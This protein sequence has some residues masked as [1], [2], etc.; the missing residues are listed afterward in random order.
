MKVNQ[1]LGV[2]PLALYVLAE[3]GFNALEAAGMLFA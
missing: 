2:I 1:L 3:L